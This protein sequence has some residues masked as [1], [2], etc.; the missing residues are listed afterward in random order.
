MQVHDDIVK[1][2][3]QGRVTC[4]SKAMFTLAW[5]VSMTCWNDSVNET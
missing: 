2:I 1:D 5:S 4:Y 3:G